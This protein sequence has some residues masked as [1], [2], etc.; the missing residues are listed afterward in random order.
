M[1]KR[2]IAIGIVV[3]IFLLS[4]VVLNA[5]ARDKIGSVSL[6]EKSVEVIDK[7]YTK[8]EMP[9]IADFEGVGKYIVGVE[10]L[11]VRNGI[12]TDFDKIALIELGDVY[13]V[14]EIDRTDS[15]KP[16]Y[17]IQLSDGNVGWTAGWFGDLIDKSDWLS[18]SSVGVYTG[19]IYSED[20]S[21]NLPIHF[22]V[23][24][25]ANG[26]IS[27]KYYY[28]KYKNF[29]EFNG[30][31]NQDGSYLLKEYIDGAYNGNIE[32]S[33][34]IDTMIGIWSNADN[35]KS[36]NISIERVK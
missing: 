9:P 12:G 31:V 17:K 25:E 2:I 32:L 14:L 34:S 13:S 15:A 3:G 30:V 22:Y 33:V 4:S 29:I 26:Q 23:L 18:G 10:A 24:T 27:G 21:V 11:N 19:A 6:V 5:M 28:D 36:F 1:K 7:D 16:W 8:K 35:T 20:K